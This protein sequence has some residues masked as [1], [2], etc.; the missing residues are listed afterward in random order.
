MVSVLHEIK[1][2]KTMIS[3]LPLAF[4]LLMAVVGIIFYTAGIDHPFWKKF[5]AIMPAIVLCCFIPAGLNTAGVFADGVGSQIYRFAATYLLPAALFLMTLSMDIPKLLGLGWKVLAMFFAASTAIILS[6]PI[7]LWIYKC[8]AP[9]QFLD[10]HLW[11]SFS[12]VAASWIGGAANQAAMK[13]LF[14]IED[15]LFGTMILVDTVNASL[16]LLVIFM[17]AK[18]A[19]KIDRWLKADTQAI[20]RVIK[21]VESYEREHARITT[22]RDFMMMF[23]LTYAVS[24][25]GLFLGKYLAQFFAHYNWAG[26]YSLDNQFFWMVISVTVIGFI[27]SLTP[28]RKL[29]N[30]GSAKIGTAF[31]FILIATIGMQINLRGLMQYWQLLLVGLLWM[32]LHIVFIFIVAKIIKAPLFYLC[33]ASN[34]NTGGASSAPIVATAFHPALAPVGVLLG[35]L[36]YVIGTVGGYVSTL[37][38]RWAVG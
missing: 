14:Q 9:E 20:D 8:V 23:G 26:T 34:A 22:L 4:G 38:M 5:Y 17:L 19:E 13:E 7:S 36:G 25:I 18:H 11:R 3:E 21:A 27:L 30:V 33:V 12:A 2:K 29:D 10:D 31:I 37:L 24:G 32:C 28:M 1:V 15:G 35:I 6:G 16:W